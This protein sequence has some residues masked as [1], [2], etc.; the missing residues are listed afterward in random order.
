MSSYLP[1]KHQ[2]LSYLLSPHKCVYV[3]YVAFYVLIFIYVLEE[4][5]KQ[6]R[7]HYP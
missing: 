4:K 2:Q 1:G 6:S 7:L 5:E 3:F